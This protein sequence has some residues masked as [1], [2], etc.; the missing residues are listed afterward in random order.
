MA[1]NQI[2]GVVL[3]L[4]PGFDVGLGSPYLPL[5]GLARYDRGGKGCVTERHTI[6]VT[7]VSHTWSEATEKGERRHEEVLTAP[8]PHRLGDRIDL[9]GRGAAP[10]GR[11]GLLGP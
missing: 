7:S 8:H 4:D 2:P 9:P 3:Q 6:V 1:G 5:R 10:L 11:V